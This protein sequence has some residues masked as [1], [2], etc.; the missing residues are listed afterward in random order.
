MIIVI[1]D[2]NVLIDLHHAGLG[3]AYAKLGMETWTTNL[4]IH[5]IQGRHGAFLDHLKTSGVLR[6][7][8][9]SLPALLTLKAVLSSALSIADASVLY[10]AE[11]RRARLLAGDAA[12]R[13]AAHA[14]HIEVGGVLWIL[15]RLLEAGILDGPSLA[16][17]LDRMIAAGARLPEAE[18]EAR[19][20][21]WR[22]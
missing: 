15:D 3:E 20:K 1:H 2:A 13:R 19:L 7:S 11:T 6:V 10:E 21:N 8:E 9:P 5:E 17:A 22:K 16:A 18:C 12:L 14:R 4:V